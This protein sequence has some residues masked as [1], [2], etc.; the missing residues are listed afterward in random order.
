MKKKKNIVIT[1][2]LIPIILGLFSCSE[3]PTE[4]GYDSPTIDGQEY[5]C[6]YRDPSVSFDGSK[7]VFYRAKVTKI[8]RG[9][10]Q[11][12][13][14]SDSTGFWLCNI[15]GSDMK[16]IYRNSSDIIS[17]PQFTPD[18]KYLVFVKNAQ[19]CKAKYS[20][21]IINEE[22]IEQLTMEGRNFFPTISPD[23][24]WIAFDSNLDSISGGYRIWK[25]KSD[26][27]RKELLISG[28]MPFW[29]IEIKWIYYIGLY[30]E[31]FKVN[32]SDTSDVIQL[33]HFN[34]KNIYATDNRYPRVSPSLRNIAFTSIKSPGLDLSVIEIK[35]TKR[36][37]LIADNIYSN[38]TWSIEDKIV[39]INYA[40]Y[41]YDINNGTIWIMNSNG[42]NKKQITMNHGLKLE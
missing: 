30:R 33:T 2:I 31:I 13:Y 5:P 10:Y 28:R 7:I 17:N 39:Y 9:G 14:D 1:F 40:P 11:N 41:N 6:P 12:E 16:I 26:G 23:G 21:D 42:S 32:I 4:D 15:D 24:N 18:M 34:E 20:G 38:C 36:K 37:Q 3:N 25:M 29:S 22:D 8:N 27:S 19:I 35:N